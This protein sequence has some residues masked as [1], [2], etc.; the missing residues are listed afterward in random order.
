MPQR[1]RSHQLESLSRNYLH[2][3]FTD[4]GWTVQDLSQD[5]GEDLLIR[6]FNSGQSS[7]L[8][9]F[10]QAKATDHLE[11]YLDKRREHILFP[12][13]VDHI[14]H[15]KKFWEPVLLTIWD[16]KTRVTYWVCVQLHIEKIETIKK[17]S[18]KTIKVAVPIANKLDTTGVTEILEI[19]QDR[20]SRF[21]TEQAGAKILCQ[22]LYT[23][24]GIEIDYDS[25]NG[26]LI[27]PQ[28]HFVEEGG[29]LFTFFG[30]QA[31]KI[32]ELE[33]LSGRPFD[34][35]YLRELMSKEVSRLWKEHLDG[36]GINPKR[37]SKIFMKCISGGN[38]TI[39]DK[40]FLGKI[41]LKKL[42]NALQRYKKNLIKD[43][44]RRRG[45]E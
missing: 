41:G 33:E 23:E 44:A 18:G 26:I 7:H 38:L 21:E 28:G 39:T 2:G 10:V 31:A 27:L 20:F 17:I 30:K 37:F 35:D 8:S 9:F 4:V 22:M 3:V 12:I 32:Q 25:Q 43:D 11:N 13:K 40:T 24:F 45:F 5:Y 34:K 6:I 14:E 15:W 42:Q 16:S 36:T 1:T 19:T 29:G